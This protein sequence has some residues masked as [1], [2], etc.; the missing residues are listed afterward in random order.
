MN[1][2]A[3]TSTSP[4]NPQF[5]RDV[6][7]LVRA[8]GR[9]NGFCDRLSASGAT[10]PAYLYVRPLQAEIVFTRP[11]IPRL[12]RLF[13]REGWRREAS[14]STHF[15]WVKR[16]EE[17]VTLRISEC[18]KVASPLSEVPPGVFQL[19]ETSDSDPGS[20]HSTGQAP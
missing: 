12:A 16:V 1:S 8:T 18:E 14:S 17:G 11:A 3:T 10:L 4:V 7:M 20:P 19:E 2:P 9:L 5:A 13:G 15:D 6:A